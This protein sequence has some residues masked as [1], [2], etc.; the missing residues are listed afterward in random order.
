MSFSNQEGVSQN[1]SLGKNSAFDTGSL[2]TRNGYVVKRLTTDVSGLPVRPIDDKKVTLE[3]A[4]FPF[5]FPFGTGAYDSRA[6]PACLPA[7]S[8]EGFVLSF[9]TLPF[10]STSDV[11]STQSCCSDEYH[12]DD[13]F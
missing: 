5:L 9:Y 4:M 1:A 8:F 10:L 3:T 6:D 2:V 13:R 12:Q 11:S 7:H